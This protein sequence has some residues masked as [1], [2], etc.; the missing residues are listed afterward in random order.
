LRGRQI[1]KLE[2]R[3]QVLKR[4]LGYMTVQ[5][6]TLQLQK[7]ALTTELITTRQARDGYF[8][9]RWFFLFQLVFRVFFNKRCFLVGR[10]G[11]R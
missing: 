10:T 2:A 6:D 11:M 4:G 7:D 1:A 8:A 5:R 3:K 9:V